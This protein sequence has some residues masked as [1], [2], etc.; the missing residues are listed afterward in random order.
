MR[1]LQQKAKKIHSLKAVLPIGIRCGA[2][3]NRTNEYQ[4]TDAGRRNLPA[5][6]F[7]DTYGTVKIK[8]L[9]GLFKSRRCLRSRSAERET[10]PVLCS[11]RDD[12]D[13]VEASFEFI[14]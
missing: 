4:K 5:S 12:R 7:R 13:L 14:W 9:V 10:A 6:V 3:Y 11:S 2:D 1:A 8:V